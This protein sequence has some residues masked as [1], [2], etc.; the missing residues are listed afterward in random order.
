MASPVWVALLAEVNEQPGAGRGGGGESTSW[1]NLAPRAARVKGGGAAQCGRD[2]RE[3]REPLIRQLIYWS[4]EVLH[5]PSWSG[6]RARVCPPS[7]QSQSAPG[8]NSSASECVA[9]TAW[10]KQE[11]EEENDF[12]KC[13]TLSMFILEDPDFPPVIFAKNFTG[14]MKRLCFSWTHFNSSSVV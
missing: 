4:T 13:Y 8:A 2:I 12:S 11:H 1:N 7:T 14:P 5:S 9:C 6:P 10:I 3:T